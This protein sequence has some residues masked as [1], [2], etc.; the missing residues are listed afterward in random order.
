MLKGRV[1]YQRVIQ[2]ERPDNSTRIFQIRNIFTFT[3]EKK[4]TEKV[5]RVSELCFMI[6]CIMHSDG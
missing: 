5:Q 4:R 1:K 3:P 2:K 6:I